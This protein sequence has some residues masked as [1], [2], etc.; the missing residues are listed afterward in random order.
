MA[1]DDDVTKDMLS[2]ALAEVA[3]AD[4][5]ASILLAALGIGFGSVFGGF[6]EGNWDPTQLGRVASV[7]WWLGAVMAL[8]SVAAAAYSLWPRYRTNRRPTE[9]YYWGHV[10][11]F[12]SFSDFRSTLEASEVSAVQR[13]EHELWYVS[14]VVHRKYTLVRVALLLAGVASIIFVLIGMV[15][16]VEANN[17]LPR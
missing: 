3:I 13:V 17:A 7:F 16:A 4:T 9:I 5:K 12:S 6:L 2:A 10:A 14:R 1:T 15:E 11:A 8:A